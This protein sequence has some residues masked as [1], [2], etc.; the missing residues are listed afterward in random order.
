M[1]RLNRWRGQNSVRPMTTRRLPAIPGL[2]HGLALSAVTDDV[3]RRIAQRRKKRRVKLHWRLCHPIRRDAD[4]GNSGSD[5]FLPRG[6]G[7][8]RGSFSLRLMLVR[9][10]H[11][12]TPSRKSGGPPGGVRSAIAGVQKNKKKKVP[13]GP[14]TQARKQGG[15]A[16]F[17][18]RGELGNVSSGFP[19]IG[20]HFP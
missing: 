9:R 16:E 10:R 4:L 15:L 5:A 13:C 17:A 2:G 19:P 18:E 6:G 1:C 11:P 3:E 20:S 7:D 14:L 12:D 8:R